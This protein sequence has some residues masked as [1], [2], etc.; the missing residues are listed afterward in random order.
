[1]SNIA[2][3][4]FPKD[5]SDNDFTRT[6]EEIVKDRFGTKL[7]VKTVVEGGRVCSWIVGPQESLV[8]E[9]TWFYEWEIFRESKRK[10]G[11][12]HPH[13]DWGTWMMTV[14]QNELACRHNGRISDEGVQGTWKGDP[15]KHQTYEEWVKGFWKISFQKYGQ[16]FIE[17]QLSYLP[18]AIR[19]L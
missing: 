10:F 17:E 15:N 14:I 3:N 19:N 1:M 7:A 11:G 8:P 12:G 9:N 18:E 4:S 2:Y 6:L 13:S 5:M 16:S